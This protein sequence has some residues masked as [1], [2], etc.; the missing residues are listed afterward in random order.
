MDEVEASTQTLRFYKYDEKRKPVAKS[1][2]VRQ[3]HTIFRLLFYR[4]GEA[5]RRTLWCKP[6]LGNHGVTTE[7]NLRSKKSW[8]A[9]VH[10]RQVRQRIGSSDKGMA[11]SP[12]TSEA[13]TP[14]AKAIASSSL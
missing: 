13:Y 4:A 1:T 3:L 6:V 11:F 12:P 9:L 10:I 14:R 2:N 5:R 8:Y 7:S